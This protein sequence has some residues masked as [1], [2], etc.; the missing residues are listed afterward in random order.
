MTIPP[1]QV[2]LVDDEA[3][4]TEAL[5]WLL[6]S[7]KI[8][9]TVF[10]SATAFLAAVRN[11]EGPLCAVLDLRMPEVSGL[12][13]QQLLLQQGHDLPLIFLSAHGDV[14]AAVNAI[15]SG[16]LD[17]LQKPFNPQVFLNSVN[18]MLKLAR[19][20]Y[21]T[22]QRRIE[23]E[24]QLG[25]LSVRETEV[26]NHLVKGHTSKEIAQL[27]DISPKT[28]DV[29]R[30]NIL[31]KMQVKTLTELRRKLEERPLPSTP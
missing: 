17:F 1:V 30:A 13:L 12:E 4:V 21:E 14:P 5:K 2:F 19:E 27:L 11:H 8:P 25:Q 9:S 10:N 20:R 7:V 24:K 26:L 29:H 18:R 31:H 23:M 15:Q 6:D 16:A 28:V 3:E 22:R